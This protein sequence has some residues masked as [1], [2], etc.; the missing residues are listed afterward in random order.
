MDEVGCSRSGGEVVGG[1]VMTM[2][3]EPFN[4]QASLGWW[5]RQVVIVWERGVG[6]NVMKMIYGDKNCS[7]RS[8]KGRFAPSCREIAFKGI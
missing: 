5:I 6:G 1:N 7:S 8:G 4:F 2:I 3:S